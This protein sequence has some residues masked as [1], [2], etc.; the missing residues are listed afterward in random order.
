VSDIAKELGG[1]P[2]KIAMTS[3]CLEHF[4]GDELLDAV[5]DIYSLMAPGGV[6]MIEVPHWDMRRWT[7]RVND[8]PHLGFF[9]V[10]AIRVLAERAGFEVVLARAFGIPHGSNKFFEVNR[11]KDFNKNVVKGPGLNTLMLANSPDNL[12]RNDGKLVRAIAIKR[13]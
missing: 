10:R 11:R 3:H 7:R 8:V 1:T 4:N 6:L 5:H 9:S 13:S 12:P 2:L